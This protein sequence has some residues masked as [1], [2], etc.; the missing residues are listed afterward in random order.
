MQQQQQQ[1]QQHSLLADV[2][3]HAHDEPPVLGV[4][5]PGLP[6]VADRELGVH[7]REGREVV[8]AA[9]Q[10]RRAPRPRLP[11]LAHALV[12]DALQHVP[13]R[14]ALVQ[15]ERLRKRKREREREREREESY[16]EVKMARVRISS[17]NQRI[18]R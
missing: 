7:P 14:R 1:Q 3:D 5:A 4:L 2:V 15:L 16:E 6:G 11:R 13:A 9:L 10:V 18:D 17:D 8:L 12:P